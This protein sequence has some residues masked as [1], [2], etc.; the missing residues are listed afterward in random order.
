MSNTYSRDYDLSQHPA[1]PVADVQLFN[2]KTDASTDSISAII[3][4]G[5]DNSIFPIKYLRQISARR[6]LRKARMTGIY[7]KCCNTSDDKL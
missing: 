7:G 1:M 3:D 6:L 2:L 4:S 5:A